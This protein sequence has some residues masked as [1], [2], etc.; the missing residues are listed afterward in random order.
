MMSS[1]EAKIVKYIWRF[2]PISILMLLIYLGYEL[3]EIFF[4]S[5]FRAVPNRV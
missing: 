1:M 5:H 3:D 2:D 4:C